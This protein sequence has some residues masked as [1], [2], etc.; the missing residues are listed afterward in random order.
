MWWRKPGLLIMP[1]YPPLDIDITYKYGYQACINKFPLVY[2]LCLFPTY[3][4]YWFYTLTNLSFFLFFFLLKV[5]PF[6]CCKPQ[7]SLGFS[8]SFCFCYYQCFFWSLL[9][10]LSQSIVE[11]TLFIYYIYS[12]KFLWECFVFPF[13]RLS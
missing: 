3:Q 12:L 7:C 5:V 4:S 11:S 13:S 1:W 8:N 9:V 10:Y 2:F 6:I